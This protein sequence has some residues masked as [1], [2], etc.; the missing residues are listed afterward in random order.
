MIVN[1]PPATLIAYLVFLTAHRLYELALSA[2]HERAL[3]ARGGHEVGRS[4]FPL[5]VALH[6][7]YPVALAAEVLALG[8]RPGVLVPL[9]LTLVAASL[10][11]RVAAHR[12]L[13]QRWTARIWVVPGEPRVSRGIYRWLRHPSY[14]GITIELV[15]G[16][17]LFGAWRTALAASALN[18]VALAIRIPIEER[19]LAEAA[20]G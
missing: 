10:A 20:R 14:V 2:R 3:R 4:H 7:L 17:L 13:G 12:A 8:A 15:A 5:F 11:L 6:A 18:L 1:V 9:W 16:S 19:A